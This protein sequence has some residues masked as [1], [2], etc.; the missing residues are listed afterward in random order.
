MPRRVTGRM[1]GA[2]GKADVGTSNDKGGAK[3]FL[4]NVNRIRVS[5]GLTRSLWAQGKDEHV[6]IHVLGRR[7][8]RDRGV[9]LP[10]AD[11]IAR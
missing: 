6:K 1:P 5:R 11:G 7:R 2:S 8:R 10:R 4:I 9:T 3:G